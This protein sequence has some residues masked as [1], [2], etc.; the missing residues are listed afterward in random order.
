MKYSVRDFIPLIALFAIISI[1]TLARHFIRGALDPISVMNDFMG[2]FFI[3]FGALKVINWNGFVEAYKMYDVVAQRS[4]AYA[5][6][7]PLIELG[8]GIAYLTR[9][10]PI[11]TNSVTL[12]VMLVSA[13]GVFIELSKGKE[14][15]CACLGVVFKLPMTYVTLL[16]DI[17]MASMAGYMLTQ[18]LI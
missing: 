11:I 3:L 5:Y 10:Q 4:T 7:Y 9:W 8:L 2:A 1:F 18:L 6:A 17:L 13:L 12:V 16:E 14:V 15:M